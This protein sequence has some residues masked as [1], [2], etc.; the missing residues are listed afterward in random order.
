MSLWV[1]RAGRH[2][3]QEETAINDGLVCHAWNELGDYSGLTRDAL[4]ES[5]QKTYP[6]ES[7]SQAAAGVSQ[8]WRFAHEIKKGDLVALPLKSQSAFEFGRVT[9]DYEYKQ[10]APNVKHIRRVEWFPNGTVQRSA[11]PEDIL[12]SLNV[13]RT[14]FKVRDDAESRVKEIL[15]LAPLDSQAKIEAAEAK[16]ESPTKSEEA[17]DLADFAHD[18]ILKFVQ[19]NFREHALARLVAAVLRAR[20]YETDVS[21]PGP[22]GGV[23]ILAGSGPFGFDQPRLCV[24]VKSGGAAESRA[25]FD[26]ILGVMSK[27]HCEQ[28]LLVSWSGFS[29]PT[30]ADARKDFFKVRLWDQGDIVDA[31]LNS[32]E[33]LDPE[34]RAELPLKRIWILS[35][36]E[37]E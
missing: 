36:E 21:A 32:Y 9:S 26:Q 22:D 5:Y 14:V 11:F 20:G 10:I 27:F 29:K 2:G 23:D 34:I 25:T 33:R 8:V 3:E 18:E 13:P 15:A 30:R 1:V 31:V 12:L 35:N 28:G 37:E 16:V 7:K 17:L 6:R 4:E 19:A 24:Q